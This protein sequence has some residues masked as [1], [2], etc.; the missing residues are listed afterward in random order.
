MTYKSVFQTEILKF[1]RQ[2]VYNNEVP[3]TNLKGT[4]KNRSYQ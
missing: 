1:I 4:D 2:E 3:V